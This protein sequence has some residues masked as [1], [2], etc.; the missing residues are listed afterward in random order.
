MK[1]IV[2]SIVTFL[3]F[4]ALFI[5]AGIYASS[6]MSATVNAEIS[7]QRV[8]HYWRAIDENLYNLL[9]ISAA[10]YG[11][12]FEINDTLPAENDIEFVL[13]NY[14]EF[15]SEYFSDP[16]IDIHLEDLNGN[17]I[18]LEDLDSKITLLP[19]N[20]T[21]EWNDW[22]KNEVE[23]NSPENSLGYLYSINLSIRFINS[24]IA[25]SSV[26]WNPY[27]SCR[28]NYPCLL[29]YVYVSDSTKTI[30]SQ[31]TEFDLSRGSKSD[32]IE[33][34]ED[35]C[36]LRLR[37]GTWGGSEPQNVLSIELQNLNISTNTKIK[38]NTTNFTANFPSKLFVGTAFAKKLS[39]L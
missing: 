27:K 11:Y 25:N 33:C 10:K 38:L 16:T 39:R 8:Y 5:L 7:S 29:L 32:L 23:I 36:W 26:T 18:S 17:R 37:V 12:V 20:I 3:I 34:T 24:A 28:P 21:Y 9:N 19:M 22:G 14:G 31:E 13:E 6:E 15:I 1:A 2:L 35:N 30:T 4:S